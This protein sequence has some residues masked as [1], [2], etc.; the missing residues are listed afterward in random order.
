MSY[1]HTLLC[2]SV[3][4][5]SALTRL[6]AAPAHPA[7]V[8]SVGFV[9]LSLTGLGLILLVPGLAFL[10][11]WCKLG[12]L[13]R[14]PRLFP[15][16]LAAA[17][18][19]LLCHYLAHTALTLA[20]ASAGYWPMWGGALFFLGLG[21]A[22]SIRWGV[23]PVPTWPAGVRFWGPLLGGLMVIG[24]CLAFTP[25]RFVEETNYWSEEL[26][27]ITGALDFQRPAPPSAALEVTYGRAWTRAAERKYGLM[28]DSA[29]I[30]ILNKTSQAMP[31]QLRLVLQNHTSRRRKARLLLDGEP[32]P[33]ER[34]ISPAE[35]DFERP[36]ETAGGTLILEPVFDPGRHTRNSPSPLRMVL[37]TFMVSPG[38][39]TLR[40]QLGPLPEAHAGACLSLYDF[41]FL[42]AAAFYGLFTRH[43][44][45]GDTGD[46]LETLDFS[47]NFKEHWIQHS[48]SYQ[49][50]RYDGGGPTAIS[51]EPPLHHFFCFLALTFIQDSI[52]SISV[53]YLAQL[54]LLF[55]LA[56]HL[57]AWRNPY[58]LWWHQLPLIGVLFAYARLCRLGVEANTPDTLFLLIWLCVMRCY[59]GGRRRLALV[60]VLASFL[61]HVPT[62]HCVIF[63]GV[64]TWVVIRERTHL[65]FM[66]K[67]LA[68]LA[69]LVLCRWLIISLEA[70]L[71]QAWSTGQADFL[72]HGR[73][74]MLKEILWQG[75]LARLPILLERT[76]DFSVLVLA[77]SCGALPLFLAALIWRGRA[78]EV[79]QVGWVFF[80]FGLLYY[81]SSSLLTIHRAHHL[82]PIAVPLI[83]AAVRRLSR[84]QGRLQGW[85]LFGLAMAAGVAAV[86]FLFVAGPDPTNTFNTIHIQAFI[87]PPNE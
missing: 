58:L 22:A 9:L 53:L 86:W 44:F 57:T 54:A 25:P 66:L 85:V 50:D 13:S 51:D 30:S 41:T 8:S 32:L 69:A 46:I 1:R 82:G 35:G 16:L 34:L 81:G 42:D 68:A 26:Y 15:F 12:W 39:H 11:L 59:L 56:A 40:L 17:L 3:L 29:A 74:D 79:D 4:V 33:R 36:G 31:L 43:F 72:A 37:P 80:L 21:T 63:L 38:R 60:L 87:P 61:V 49:G 55:L 24:F 62:P 2:L 10:P 84:L 45:V 70:G 5:F 73:F 65:G 48:S 67:A 75:D 47:R 14:R 64:I 71:A 52:I 83:I 6:V 23:A 76:L 27:D 28:G 20:G 77:A 78:K 19:T 18:S 7:E